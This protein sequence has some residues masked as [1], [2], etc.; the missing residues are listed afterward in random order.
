MPARALVT[1]T[2]MDDAVSIRAARAEANDRARASVLTGVL[3]LLSIPAGLALAAYSS[4]IDL[5]HVAVAVPVAGVLGIVA[6][7]L[8]RNARRHSQI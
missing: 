5:I 2:V 7:A 4:T 6:M 3:A 1:I 8:A